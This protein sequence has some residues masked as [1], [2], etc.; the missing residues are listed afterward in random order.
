MSSFILWFRW[1]E[2]CNNSKCTWNTLFSKSAKTCTQALWRRF[3]PN[4]NLIKIKSCIFALNSW[5]PMN[6]PLISEYIEAIKTAEECF[7][8]E[9]EGRTEAYRMIVE[10]LEYVSSTFLTPIKSQC[11][12]LCVTCKLFIAWMAKFTKSAQITAYLL[13]FIWLFKIYYV[14]LWS[15]C[16]NSQ[17]LL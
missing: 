1:G 8:K 7:L 5:K 6:Y 11:A 4:N 10:E 12:W 9:Q 3:F 17:I 2:I 14:T 16:D 13:L 15:K